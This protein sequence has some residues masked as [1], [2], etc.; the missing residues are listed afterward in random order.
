M[1][2]NVEI[3]WAMPNL[4]IEEFRQLKRTFQSL[5]AGNAGSVTLFEQLLSRRLGTHAVAVNNGT[6]A[7]LACLMAVGVSPG[8][9][10]IA[11][12]YTFASVVGTI[13]TLGARPVLVD[14]DPRT[15]NMDMEALERLV[16]RKRNVKAVV[17]V[18]V[19]GVPGDIDSL[20]ELSEEYDFA[21][22]EDAAEGL[23]AEFRHRTVG[24]YPH[25]TTFSFHPAKQITTIEGGAI[26]TKDESLA[27]KVR[28]IVNHGMADTYEHVTA[29]LNFRLSELQSAIGIAQLHKLDIFLK[30]RGEIAHSYMEGLEGSFEIQSIPSYVTKASWGMFLFLATDALQRERIITRLAKAGIEARRPWRPVHMQPFYASLVNGVFPRAERIFQR[31]VAPPLTN[32]MTLYQADRVLSL[33]RGAA[34]SSTT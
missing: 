31:V 7:I 33:I 17:H 4:G 2:K 13:T 19:S 1:V 12:T 28:L 23:G 18:D 8:D 32:G 21:L 9:Y 26:A 20:S 16:R 29:G 15:F 22:I 14:S 34:K 3:P 30:K 10:V 5:A 6:S 24:S 25:L 11:P 27:R